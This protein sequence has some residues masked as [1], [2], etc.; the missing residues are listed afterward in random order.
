M[1][2]PNS[3]LHA[4]NMHKQSYTSNKNVHTL[5]KH[6]NLCTLHWLTT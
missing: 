6:C 4:A 5:S 3:L 2:W 1:V